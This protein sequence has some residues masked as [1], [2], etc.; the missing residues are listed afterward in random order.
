[1]V[2][3]KVE[4]QRKRV[5]SW[6][7]LIGLSRHTHAVVGPHW[8][9]QTRPE[10]FHQQRVVRS[11]QPAFTVD[12]VLGERH[13]LHQVDLTAVHFSY[14]CGL[15][16]VPG[17]PNNKIGLLHMFQLVNL[18]R[19]FEQL[20][21]ALSAIFN[22]LVERLCVAAEP[23]KRVQVPVSVCKLCARKLIVPVSPCHMHFFVKDF[24]TVPV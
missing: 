21:P 24:D 11:N 13:P 1:M 4:V 16:L 22:L 23:C 14:N 20:Y 12:V 3:H 9:P 8:K 17:R 15:S 5:R 10:R 19:T 2:C 18:I 7:D 6:V